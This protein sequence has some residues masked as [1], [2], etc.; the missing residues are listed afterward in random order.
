MTRR[1][2]PHVA[3]ID[4]GKT[5]AKLAL[6]DGVNMQEIAVLTRPNAVKDAAPY[7][8]FD[9]DGIWSFMMDGLSDLQAAHGVDAISVT[10]HGASGVL[11]NADGGLACPVLDYEHT[12]PDDLAAAYDALRPDF[13]ETGSPRL[14]MGLNLGAQIHWLFE[15]QAGLDSRTALVATYPQFWSGRLSGSVRCDPSSLGTHTDLWAPYAG[16]FSGLVET[17]GL[18]GR[19]APV[20]PADTCL[21]PV[22]PEIS[23]A[24][25]LSAETPVYCGIHDSNASLLPHLLDRTP[26]FA[27][28]STGTWVISM[29]VGGAKVDLTPERDTLVNVDAMGRPVPS[30]RFIGGR[31]FELLAHETAQPDDAAIARVT[32]GRLFFMPSVEPTSGPYQGIK[33][34]WSDETASPQ[35]KSAA[36]SYYLALMT[37]VS[38]DLIAASGPIIVEGP[39]GQNRLYLDMLEAATGRNTIAAG[40]TT[41]TSVGAALL[42]GGT[43]ADRP[44]VEVPPR[45]DVQAGLPAYAAAWRDRVRTHMAEGAA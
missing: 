20:T 19:M 41:G 33:G 45:R 35:E 36:L 44:V 29:G 43:R 34:G 32:S 2:A 22:L 38:L 4:I 24:T 1:A 18:A 9:V 11:L 30:A 31:E 13:T 10:T 6:V 5:N 14:P 37:S 15:T 16:A 42:V 21:G 23:R 7:P 28:V 39:F 12:G 3:V 26:P 27:V 25:G 17:L 40:G 8:H